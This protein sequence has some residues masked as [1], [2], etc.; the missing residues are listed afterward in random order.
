MINIIQGTLPKTGNYK[1]GR[2]SDIKYIVIHYTA[3]KGDTAL[4]NVKYFANNK[5]SASAHFFVDEL[6]IYSSVPITYTAYHCGGSLQGNA[7]HTFFGKC[8][9]SNSIGIE[10]CLWDKQGNIRQGTI[11][12]TIELTKHLMKEYGIPI[13]NVIRHWDVTGKLCPQPMVGNYNKMWNDFKSALQEDIDMD[14]LKRISEVLGAVGQDLEK[15]LQK[16]DALEKENNR[17]NNIINL[18]GQDIQSIKDALSNKE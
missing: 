11:D 9:N 7:G 10:M 1:K 6:S 13:E 8:T 2:A 18:V 14:E 17:Q 16:L 12:N 5:V 3:N 4:N 15:I